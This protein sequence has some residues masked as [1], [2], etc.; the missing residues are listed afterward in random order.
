MQLIV[1]Y[2]SGYF[3]SVVLIVS[4]PKLLNLRISYKSEQE[5]NPENINLA[6]EKVAP[7]GVDVCSGV[8]SLGDLDE[9]KL[10]SFFENLNF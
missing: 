8:C 6:V 7:F 5:L 10:R 9:S 1:L 3:Y 4:F 2:L